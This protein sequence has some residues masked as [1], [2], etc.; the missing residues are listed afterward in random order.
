M[1]E[2]EYNELRSKMT[3]DEWTIFNLRR[4]LQTERDN[5]LEAMAVIEK[6]VELADD[7]AD[8]G[9]SRPARDFLKKWRQ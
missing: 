3:D 7:N 5:W 4:S 6:T 9:I 8:S 2:T 1:D